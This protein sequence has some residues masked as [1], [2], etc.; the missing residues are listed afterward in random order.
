MK[1]VAIDQSGCDQPKFINPFTD[2]GFKRIFG[3]E[4]SKDILI[5][6][7]N[8]LIPEA[9]IE[10]LTYLNVEDLP[11]NR[12]RSRYVFDLLCQNSMQEYFLV[13][14]QQ[15]RQMHFTNRIL[16]YLSSLVERL[17]QPESEPGPLPERV[18]GRSEVVG[19]SDG[20]DRSKS[21]VDPA[22]GGQLSSRPS[23]DAR[24][25]MNR[26]YSISMLN[27]VIKDRYP[28]DYRW[29]V[30]RMDDKHHEKFGDMIREIYL[31][32]PKFRLPLSEC[33]T[34]YEKFLYVFKN[35]DILERM[36]KELQN[37]VFTKLKNISEIAQMSPDDRLAY[38]ISRL[39]EYDTENALYTK[40][41]EGRED[42]LA[43]G[44][45]KG[46]GEERLRMALDMLKDGL[47]LQM[48]IRY[49]GLTKEQIQSLA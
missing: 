16:A 31:E 19:G 38:E 1:R 25:R 10:N 20:G 12:Y 24:Y 23:H 45:K 34:L 26:I 2:Y 15:A 7:L 11:V 42:G 48:I 37:Q 28:D 18:G 14:M 27:Y 3:T 6:F 9:D 17:M 5:A 36:P 39:H 13:E 21:I 33:T 47:D 32:I 41:E 46:R 22:A 4:L 43:E 44:E 35:M 49:T 29:D 40:Y 8:S 30:Y